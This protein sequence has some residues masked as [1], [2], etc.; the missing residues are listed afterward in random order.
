MNIPRAQEG[1]PIRAQLH[2]CIEATQSTADIPH[3]P[4]NPTDK[5]KPDQRRRQKDQ[6]HDPEHQEQQPTREGGREACGHRSH[7]G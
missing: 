7:T 2:R 4:D 6:S 3:D 5:G 1:L